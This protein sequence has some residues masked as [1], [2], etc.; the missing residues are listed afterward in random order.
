MD[1]SRVSY[2]IKLFCGR[3]LSVRQRSDLYYNE[4]RK[5]IIFITILPV[6]LRRRADTI[7]VVSEWEGDNSK[8]HKNEG[9][10]KLKEVYK[11]GAK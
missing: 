1:G 8:G 4:N 5:S 11:E 2:R 10:V 7:F 3:V 6:K 9:R